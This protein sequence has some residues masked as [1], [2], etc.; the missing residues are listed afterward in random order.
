MAAMTKA[1]LERLRIVTPWDHRGLDARRRP[2]IAKAHEER[3]MEEA[4]S[5][6][7]SVGPAADTCHAA[8]IA[9]PVARLRPLLAVKG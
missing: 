1:E 6:Y 8:G 3:L 7:K 5:A 9:S 2:D 4:P